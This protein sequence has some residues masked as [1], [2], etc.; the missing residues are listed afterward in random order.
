MAT[1]SP[2]EGYSAIAILSQ[3]KSTEPITRC[4]QE[5]RCKNS[6][7]LDSKNLR[8]CSLQSSVSFQI[9]GAAILVFSLRL[10]FEKV[11]HANRTLKLRSKESFEL[12]LGWIYRIRDKHIFGSPNVLDS[13]I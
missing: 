3:R 13:A 7:P 8:I 10:K 4:E 6:P 9:S 2:L 11:N 5:P 12:F 1:D